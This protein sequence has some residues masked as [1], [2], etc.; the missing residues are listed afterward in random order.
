MKAE[1]GIRS[2]AV[3]ATAS[4]GVR[5]ACEWRW[6]GGGGWRPGRGRAGGE[7]GNFHAAFR[8]GGGGSRPLTVALP[9]PLS[10]ALPPL[11]R[12]PHSPPLNFNPGL[13]D[14]GGAGDGGA[15]GRAAAPSLHPKEA[16]ASQSPPHLHPRGRPD[17]ALLFSSLSRR[18]SRRCIRRAI[19]PKIR[20][21][22]APG[23]PSSQPP[24][25][26]AAYRGSKVTGTDHGDWNCCF[27]LPVWPM[28]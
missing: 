23:K 8:E 16:G 10:V 7:Q 28:P 14:G 20:S 26:K 19:R 24:C 1:H 25:P 9:S 12:C 18:A 2:E 4:S 21:P 22:A 11:S 6:G 17:K 5:A 15:R 13:G 3:V 27:D